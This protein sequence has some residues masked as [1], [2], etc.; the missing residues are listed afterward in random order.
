MDIYL[1]KQYERLLAS[2]IRDPR[3]D[4]LYSAQ[5]LSKWIME[6]R[7][8]PEELVN[9]HIST[10][11]KLLPDLPPQLKHSFD[12]LIEVMI[13]YGVAYQETE[14]LVNRQR[15]LENEIDV[16]ARMQQTL[17]PENPP[18]LPGTEIGVISVAAN[19]MSGDYYNFVDHGR[20][21]LGVA[22]S[23]IIGKGIPAALCMSMIKYAMDRLDDHPLP[24]SEVLRDLNTVVERNVDPSMFITMVYGVYDSLNHKFR[25]STAGHEPGFIYHAK[26]GRFYELKTKGLVL[27]VARD[28][29]Y[30]EYTVKLAPGDAIILLSDGVTECKVDGK[31]MKRSKLKRLIREHLALP[32]QQAVEAIHQKLLEM[33]NYELN[34]DQTI[35]IIKRTRSET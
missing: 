34:D 17:L 28:V 22:I 30:P 3:E 9:F 10:V 29:D 19:R 35:L 32:A 26:A 7:I 11:K 8:P 4:H 18:P 6:Q 16:A 25:Y 1:Q 15:E 13:G 14:K 20:H 5:Q 33:T 23:D 12:L 31:F 27:G 24:P 21:S 2:Y